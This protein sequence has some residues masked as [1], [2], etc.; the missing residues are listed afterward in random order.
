MARISEASDNIG[1]I[2]PL[3]VAKILIE[4]ARNAHGLASWIRSGLAEKI[5]K[6]L[7]PVK[8]NNQYSNLKEIEAL[9]LIKEA[10]KDL[11][12]FIKDISSNKHT[13]IFL[14]ISLIEAWEVMKR[15]YKISQERKFNDIISG[16][17]LLFYGLLP[18]N[19]EISTGKL[20]LQIFWVC[21][22]VADIKK[23]GLLDKL[24]EYTMRLRWVI[25]EL[26]DKWFWNETQDYHTIASPSIQDAFSSIIE[27]AKKVPAVTEKITDS[28]L[29]WISSTN[30]L[31]SLYSKALNMK[32]VSL[33]IEQSD[34][35]DKVFLACNYISLSPP[36]YQTRIF[37]IL[38][39][40]L[41][42][43]IGVDI[44]Q[45]SSPII[46]QYQLAL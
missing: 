34:A 24:L 30:A 25:E 11:A 41:G 8:F 36:Q 35:M 26:E 32:G 9:N 12:K 3:K 43:L 20:N 5:E 28:D 14:P 19:K 37:N 33:T 46:H 40:S 27:H 16:L 44:N 15:D 39:D 18:D 4:R 29:E 17:F 10:Y 31:V 7:D 13:H 45:E 6:T 2:D 1:D 42:R 23:N 21:I 38:L 22:D